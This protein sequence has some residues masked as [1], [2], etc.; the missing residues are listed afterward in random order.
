MALGCYRLVLVPTD[1]H[2]FIFRVGGHVPVVISLLDLLVSLPQKHVTTA[3]CHHS[4]PNRNDMTK[5]SISC[6]QA[7]GQ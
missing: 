5:V 2:I 6:R 3:H 4:W 1:M 7:V